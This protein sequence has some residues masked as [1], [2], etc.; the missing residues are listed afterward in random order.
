[1]YTSMY[2]TSSL[3]LIPIISYQCIA[4]DNHVLF[5][6][7]INFK[8]LN[9]KLVPNHFEIPDKSQIVQTTIDLGG[10]LISGDCCG[11]CLYDDSVS[12]IIV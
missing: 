5:D 12:N 1:M 2:E 9:N 4:K 11:L 3:H 10:L 8:L 7:I 6:H